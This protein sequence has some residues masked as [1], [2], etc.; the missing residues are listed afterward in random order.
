M[1]ELP[2]NVALGLEPGTPRHYGFDFRDT[3]R[4]EFIEDLYARI[5]EA[6]TLLSEA[7]RSAVVD[8]ALL[9]FA[10]NAFVYAEEPMTL[11]AARGA[12]NLVVGGARRVFA[13]S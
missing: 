12:A 10:H 9:A 2:F 3:G 5:N 7:E 8:E 11:D 1:L 4:R 6:G 13:S